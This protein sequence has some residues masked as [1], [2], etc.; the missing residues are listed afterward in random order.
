MT[1][2][3]RASTSYDP[4]H[5]R[6]L[7]AVSEASSALETVL[8]MVL[9]MS[10]AATRSPTAIRER[11]DQI[12]KRLIKRAAKAAADPT[13]R[14]FLDRCFRNDDRERGGNA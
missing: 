6:A 8:V 13:M 12:R 1:T 3:K 5:E 4:D 2:F 14:D 9:A 7:V 10:P 11:T